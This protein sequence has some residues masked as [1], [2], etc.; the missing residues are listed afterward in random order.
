MIDSLKNV[1]F[2]VGIFNYSFLA[3]SGW[4]YNKTCWENPWGG[5]WGLTDGDYDIKPGACCVGMFEI[6]ELL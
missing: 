3:D 6:F 4:P 5:S 2:K 1:K